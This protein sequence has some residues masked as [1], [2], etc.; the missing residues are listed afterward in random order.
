MRDIT[1]YLQGLS[2][3]QIGQKSPL[4]VGAG[5]VVVFFSEQREHQNDHGED[6]NNHR[7][8]ASRT[9][10]AIVSDIGIIARLV[11]TLG[12]KEEKNRC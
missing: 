10:D 9:V 1:V 4:D 6:K 3:D 8:G 12:A 2:E 5:S 11:V 7:R